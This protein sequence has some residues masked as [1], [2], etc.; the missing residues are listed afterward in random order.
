MS[1]IPR[2]N[3]TVST[4]NCNSMNVSTLGKRNAKTYLK[5]EGITNKKADVILITD[6]RAS[7]K[8]EELKKLMG[9]TQNGSYKLYLNS[10]SDS[11]GVGIAIKRNIQHVIRDTY[12]G[13]GDENALLI[14][15]EIKNVVLTIG[16]IYGPNNNDVEFYRCIERKIRMWG[17]TCILGGDFNTILCDTPGAENLDRD[18]VG[19]VPNR[20]NSR[21]INEWI[22]SGIFI[23]PFRAL[24]PHTREFSY[25]PF[26]GQNVGNREI[27]RISKS[28]LDFFLVSP[29]ILDVINKVT[30]EDR[31]GSDFDHKEVTLE[32]GKKTK[33]AKITIYDSTLNDEIACDAVNMVV[34]ESLATNLLHKDMG[35]ENNV[36]QLGILLR[37]K[38]KLLNRRNIYGVTDEVKQ[39][40]QTVNENIAVIQNR[41]PRLGPLME[42]E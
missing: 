15:I 38:E 8:G 17:N 9:L 19:R 30:Y 37:D 26:R 20:Q 3:L 14:N 5:I 34:Y 27:P 2:F 42:R 16:A 39:R 29:N 25:I 40:I 32:I 23:D 4:I 28:R 13:R 35:I 11:R 7:N 21:L 18:G 6:I 41:L 22:T 33:G 36:A 31:I 10:S 1:N 12:V 24:Y